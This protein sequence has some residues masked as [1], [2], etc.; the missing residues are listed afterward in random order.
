MLIK[1]EESRTCDQCSIRQQVL[2]VA[3]GDKSFRLC[4]GCLGK[5][6][7]AY[8]RVGNEAL[9]SIETW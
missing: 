8:Y 7:N 6:V 9:D 5:L 2:L 3:F 4:W 1:R